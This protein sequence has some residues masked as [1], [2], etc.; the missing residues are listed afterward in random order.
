MPCVAKFCSGRYCRDMTRPPMPVSPSAMKLLA[1]YNS[2]GNVRELE[3][4]IERAVVLTTENEIGP[5]DLALGPR[6]KPMGDLSSLLDLPIHVSVQAHKKVLIR[7]AI[8][9]A[10]GNKTNAA[11]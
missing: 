1:E 10:K 3:N 2:P 6:E 4:V 9:K 11:T 8:N 5:H 7:H